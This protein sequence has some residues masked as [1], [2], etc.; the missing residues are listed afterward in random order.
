VFVQEGFVLEK[1]TN[2]SNVWPYP[3]FGIRVKNRISEMCKISG[4]SRGSSSG[5]CIVIK[6]LCAAV[7]PSDELGKRKRR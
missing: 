6:G 2:S 3:G 5:R 7:D 4:R 1:T